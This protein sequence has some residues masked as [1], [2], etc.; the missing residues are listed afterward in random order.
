MSVNFVSIELFKIL[1]LSQTD[2]GDI[3]VYQTYLYVC[4]FWN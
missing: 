1:I 2:L 4:I 3:V